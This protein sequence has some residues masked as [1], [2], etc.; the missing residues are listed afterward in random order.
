MVHPV[1]NFR[2]ALNRIIEQAPCL[3]W[4]WCLFNA[5]PRWTGAMSNACSRYTGSISTVDR[6]PVQYGFSKM[7][8][9][10]VLCFY[11][12]HLST[13]LNMCSVQLRCPCIGFIGNIIGHVW[14]LLH[15]MSILHPFVDPNTPT[16]YYGTP[17]ALP[18]PCIHAPGRYQ[19]SWNSLTSRYSYM[20]WTEREKVTTFSC[21][22]FYHV[23]S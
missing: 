8:R 14:P 1:Q 2:Q 16:L 9:P 6:V 23:A 7:N 20:L 4:T 12:C 11:T 10:P 22:S 21:H 18:K 5:C 17:K 3:R 15:S 19:R 13:T